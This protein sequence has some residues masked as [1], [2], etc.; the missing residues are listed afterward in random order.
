MRAS[1]AMALL[2]GAAFVTPDVVKAM[3]PAV[4]AHRILVR[5]QSALRGAR[6]TDVVNDI[7]RRV[8]VPIGRD[9]PA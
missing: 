5:P 2:S 8:E 4:L 7:L 6:G 3:A 9:E 1:Q